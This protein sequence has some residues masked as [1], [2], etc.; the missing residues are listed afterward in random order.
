MSYCGDKIILQHKDGRSRALVA[1][2]KCWGCQQCTPYNMKKVRWK[3]IR[4]APNKFLT[5]P[6]RKRPD[7]TPAEMLTRIRTA[8]EILFKRLK[9]ALKLK[10]LPYFVVVEATKRGWPHLHLLLRCPYLPKPWLKRVWQELTGDYILKI[11]QIK[12]PKGLVRYV[13]K[14]LSEAPAKFGRHKRYWCSQDWDLKTK[15]QQNTDWKGAETK[16][17]IGVS[18][19]HYLALVHHAGFVIERSDDLY[20]EAQAPPGGGY[21]PLWECAQYPPRRPK[22]RVREDQ[23]TFCVSS[24][25]A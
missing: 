22:R 11:K 5:L 14:Y 21:P 18:I 7:E 8:L 24:C 23:S 10:T 6:A 25:T 4:G 13:S 15:D 20:F 2:C 1:F 9:R 16:I 19:T 12:N 17:L 3:A